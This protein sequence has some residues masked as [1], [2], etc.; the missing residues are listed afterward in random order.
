MSYISINLY[1]NENNQ[2][3]LKDTISVD[4]N[5]TILELRNKILS[6][7]FDKVK[8]NYVKLT[9]ITEKVYKDYGLLFFE[10]GLLAET[11]DN[12]NLNK[13]TIEKRTFDFLAEPCNKEIIVKNVKYRQS[14]DSRNIYNPNK[15]FNPGY[16]EKIEQKEFVFN[17]EDFPPLC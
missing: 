14:G 7:L 8:Y 4:L 17:E 6:I 12:Y 2:N 10:K 13:F 3:N 15:R 16:E 1:V 11:L 9:N 5:I